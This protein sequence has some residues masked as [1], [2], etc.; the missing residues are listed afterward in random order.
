MY[1][2]KTDP[3]NFKYVGIYDI[4][5]YGSWTAN[6]LDAVILSTLQRVHG[7]CTGCVLE[8]FNEVLVI[9]S[10]YFLLESPQ[11]KNKMK[12]QA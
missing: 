1:L 8:L 2:Y 12:T 11:L 4:V 5:A 9:S 10:Q 3:N 7:S 6:L